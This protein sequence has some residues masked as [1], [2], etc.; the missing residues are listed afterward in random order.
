MTRQEQSRAAIRI[1]MALREVDPF[2]AGIDV[3]VDGTA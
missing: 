2:A 3:T 1:A